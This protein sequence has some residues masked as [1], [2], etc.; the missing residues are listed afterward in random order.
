MG[1]GVGAVLGFLAPKLRLETFVV[2]GVVP[3]A[4]VEAPYFFIVRLSAV[5]RS[6][7]SDIVVH[8]VC[9]ALAARHPVVDIP[10]LSMELR[11]ADEARELLPGHDME[12][13]SLAHALAPRFDPSGCKNDGVSAGVVLV[14]ATACAKALVGAHHLHLEQEV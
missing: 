3:A 8:V 13:Q 11:V 4:A 10:A 5:A 12:V 1:E 14:G 7:Q 9:P 6:A 2:E